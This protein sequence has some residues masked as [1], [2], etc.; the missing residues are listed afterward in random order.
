MAMSIEKKRQN[1]NYNPREL[2]Y[3]CIAQAYKKQIP[4]TS[5]INEFLKLYDLP[6]CDKRFFTKLVK[7]VA[8][9]KISLDYVIKTTN[10]Q[11]IRIRNNIKI[12]LYLA[13]YE[14]IFLKKEQYAII[15]EY[16]ELIKNRSKYSTSFANA[17]LHNI[18]ESF[19]IPNSYDFIYG[20][21]KWTLDYL[22]DLLGNKEAKRFIELS[23]Q[24]SVLQ[25]FPNYNSA[26]EHNLNPD[27][28]TEDILD[29]AKAGK[30][31]IADRA[32]QKIA[33]EI[34]ELIGKGNDF[35]EV[36]AGNGTKSALIKSNLRILDKEVSR[37]DVLDVSQ[38][39][40]SNLKE[41]T[42]LLNFR[43][44]N[45]FLEDASIWISN[46]T[47]DTIFIDAPCSGLGTIRRHPEIKSRI[48]EE[49]FKQY[50]DLN[51]KI[52][53]NVSK[54]VKCDGY[55]IYATCTISYEENDLVAKD[56]LSNTNYEISKDF[57][58][59]KKISNAE[60]KEDEDA[61]YCIVFKRIS[62]R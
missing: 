31:I 29:Y 21:Y 55:L 19:V 7:G 28:D 1:K 25:F 52:L 61:H 37:Y 42:K 43:I 40:L 18:C 57:I 34:A 5:L 60:I 56:F 58:L 33:S 11:K 9:Y 48:K 49:V 54:Y 16:V 47:Y 24:D 44:D 6:E 62:E 41:R 30:I 26:G 22:I 17:F 13:I 59:Y 53:N 2:A 10:V 35:L 14:L 12:Y 27:C 32:S 4:E 36:G 3:I 45:C 15:N 23:D 50:H 8:R 46:V 20:Y 51:L 38:I 39:R